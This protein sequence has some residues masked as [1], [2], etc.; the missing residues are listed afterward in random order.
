L[1]HM[2]IQPGPSIRKTLNDL[3]KARLDEQVTTR[4][5]EME[6]VGRGKRMGSWT[7]TM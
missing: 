1:I 5:D 6:F 3:L 2:G 7:T 4:Q